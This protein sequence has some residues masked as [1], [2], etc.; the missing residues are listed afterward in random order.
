MDKCLVNADGDITDNKPLFLCEWNDADNV[1]IHTRET[2]YARY[3]DTGLYDIDEVGSWFYKDNHIFFNELLDILSINAALV[4][5]NGR[6]DNERYSADNMSI[7]RI[8]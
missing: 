6:F 7:Q 1:E 5:Q 4:F 3:K 2:L 8:Y